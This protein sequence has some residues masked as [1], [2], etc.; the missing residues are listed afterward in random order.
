MSEM[1]SMRQQKRPHRNG[2]EDEPGSKRRKDENNGGQEAVNRVHP[3]RSKKSPRLSP[4]LF[5]DNCEIQPQQL[6]QLLK[7]AAIGK[8][9]GATQARCVHLSGGAQV[10]AGG[11]YSAGCP[12]TAGGSYSAGSFVQ[13]LPYLRCD[14]PIQKITSA[15]TARGNL[16]TAALCLVW[17]VKCV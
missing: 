9:G 4:A 15:P 12:I 1:K 14:H 8:R 7:Y 10:T 17:I 2:E 13:R 16:R 5:C 11:S 3:Q 6:H